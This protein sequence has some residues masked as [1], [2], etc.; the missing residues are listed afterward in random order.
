MQM[1]EEIYTNSLRIANSSW[2]DLILRSK[3]QE[4][5]RMEEVASSDVEATALSV[6]F[7]L[8]S[9]LRLQIPSRNF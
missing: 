5:L 2:A 9:C 4:S 8:P 3:K 1:K 6:Q 7:L